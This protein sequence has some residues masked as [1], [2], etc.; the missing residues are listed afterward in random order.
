MV[1]KGS[2]NQLL[3]GVKGVLEAGTNSTNSNKNKRCLK[4]EFRN[5]DW[6]SVGLP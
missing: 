3:L 1:M 6:C 5:G 2:E 4:S